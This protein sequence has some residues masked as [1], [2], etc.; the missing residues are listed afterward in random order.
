M[1]YLCSAYSDPDKAVMEAR[2]QEV[3]KLCAELMKKGYVVFSPIAH[4]HPI[5]QHGLPT[6]FEYWKKYDEDMIGM[7]DEVWVY[8]MPGWDTSKGV[9][10][11]MKIALAQSKPIKS[12][13][14][15]K[16]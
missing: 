1:I 2:F 13:F 9:A 4:C 5:A 3:C 15:K 7:C 11:E 14:P 16:V 12:L 10:A 6:D 8:M